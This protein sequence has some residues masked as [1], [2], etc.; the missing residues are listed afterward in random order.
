MTLSSKK[1]KKNK[2]LKCLNTLRTKLVTK[3]IYF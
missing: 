3:K 1:K 2:E